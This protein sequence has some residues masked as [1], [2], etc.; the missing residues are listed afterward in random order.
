MEKLIV[1]FAQFFSSCYANLG[2]SDSKS[3]YMIIYF[4]R[5]LLKCKVLTV[6]SSNMY[7][8]INFILLYNY[9]FLVHKDCLCV[10]G[11]EKL[12]MLTTLFKFG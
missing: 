10:A 2:E 4:C 8:F 7:I 9:Y 1:N 12:R 11:L 3:M 5:L 6:I